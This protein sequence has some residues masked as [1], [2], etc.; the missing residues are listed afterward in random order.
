MPRAKRRKPYDP[1]GTHDRRSQDLPFNAEVATVEID[2]PLALELGEKIVAF[3]S[4]RSDPLG[5]LH[6]HRQIDETQYR[7]GRAFQNDWEKAERGPRAVDTTREY[8]DGGQRREPI[9]E[10]QRQATLRLNRAEHELGADGSALVH[11][12]L[13]LGMTMEQVGQRRGLRTQRWQDYF[14]R[15]LKECLDRLALMYGLATPNKVPAKD[16]QR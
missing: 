5:R 15:R 11:D 6:A 7:S 1:A 8:V 14:A 10:G 9:T 4:I 16:R 3:R 2:D 13:I 12:V